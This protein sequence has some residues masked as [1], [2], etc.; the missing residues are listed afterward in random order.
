MTFREERLRS[1]A[2]QDLIDKGRERFLKAR[3]EVRPF[4]PSEKSLDACAQS[5]LCCRA[6]RPGERVTRS[7]V[8]ERARRS[9]PSWFS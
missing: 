9:Y 2:H 8:L 3:Y 7:M 1:L 4:A 6:E 5:L